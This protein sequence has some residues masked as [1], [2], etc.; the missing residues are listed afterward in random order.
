MHDAWCMAFVELINYMH[1][2]QNLS[3]KKC[4]NLATNTQDFNIITTSAEPAAAVK[5]SF[6]KYAP[7]PEILSKMSQKSGRHTKPAKFWMF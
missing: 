3:L 1:C 7:G 6:E 5:I 2:Q 4:L